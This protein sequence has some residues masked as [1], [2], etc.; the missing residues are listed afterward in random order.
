MG[1]EL[2]A[3]MPPNPTKRPLMEPLVLLAFVAAWVAIQIWVLPRAGVS[4]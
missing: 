2:G 4:P 1:T 3:A